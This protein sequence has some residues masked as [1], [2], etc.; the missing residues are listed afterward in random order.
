[1]L[2]TIFM[3]NLKGGDIDSVKLVSRLTFN[4]PVKITLN[5]YALNFP[6]CIS[7]FCLHEHFR[8]QCNNYYNLYHLVST[9][10]P[11]LKTNILTHMLHF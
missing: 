11:V 8:V 2:N 9:S 5:F 4:V 10:I 7:N 6:R 3:R 1:M